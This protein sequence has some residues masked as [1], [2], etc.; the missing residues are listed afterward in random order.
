MSYQTAYSQDL[1]SLLHFCF[2]SLI[3]FYFWLRLCQG[4]EFVAFWVNLYWLRVYLPCMPC[5]PSCPTFLTCLRALRAYMLY[6]LTCFKC[7]L[8]FVP[9]LLAYLPLFTCLTFF[10]CL[11]CLYFH[12]C[13]TC[14]NFLRALDPYIL[15]LALRAFPFL[16]KCGT[17]PNINIFCQ[18]ID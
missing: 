4:T 10:T 18:L 15:L 9:L 1:S 7:M 2:F 3:I 17:T 6:V 16:I 5:V 11:T 13:L 12:T 8:A 14:I